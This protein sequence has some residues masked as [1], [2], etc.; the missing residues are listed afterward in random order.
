MTTEQD[1]LEKAKSLVGSAQATTSTNFAARPG[2]AIGAA[3]RL[4]A[5][6]A[7]A[8]LEIAGD[9]RGIRRL[10]E[11]EEHCDRERRRSP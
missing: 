7:L 1:R 10:C 4:G 5:A 8:L 11:D 2:A 9:V 3:L 6:V